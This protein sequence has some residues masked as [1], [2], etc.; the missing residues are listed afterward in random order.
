LS[1][2]VECLGFVIVIVDICYVPKL[3]DASDWP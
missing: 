1:F 3:P 2:S